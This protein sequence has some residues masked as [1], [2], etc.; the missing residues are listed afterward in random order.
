MKAHDI[1]IKPI[2]SEK[3]NMGIA[4][5]TYSFIVNKKATKTEIKDAVKEIFNVNVEKVNTVNYDGKT[6][7][8]GRHEGKTP[9]YKKAIVFLT[10]DSKGIEFFDSLI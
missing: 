8:V 3:S 1:I 10:A 7:R 6:K 9:S 2:L 4:Q 5:K